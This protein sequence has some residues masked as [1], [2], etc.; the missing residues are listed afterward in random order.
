[1]FV[2]PDNGVL[3]AAV[4][5][6]GVQVIFS[7]DA[8]RLYGELRSRFY[9]NGVIS[10]LLE[11]GASTTFHGRDLFAPLA[12]YLCSGFPVSNVGRPRDGMV[13]LELPEPVV[14]EGSI[15]GR[16][17]YIDHYGNIITNIH[18]RFLEGGGEVYIKIRGEMVHVGS[19][20]HTYDDVP[21]GHAAA[22]VSSRERLEIAVNG[23][24][25]AEHFGA[26][27]N[28]EI[29]VKKEDK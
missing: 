7:L 28:D 29:L 3:S 19:M 12:A 20:V 13:E 5:E 1:M 21:A 11:R 24:S 26:S 2:G 10:R 16:V 17:V 15:T 4:R 23:G 9:G 6:D 22:L 18:H 14:D 25:A 27:E 8:D